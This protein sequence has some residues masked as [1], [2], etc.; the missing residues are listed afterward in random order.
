MKKI[1]DGI[2]I[3]NQKSVF[4]L[5]SFIKFALFGYIM[6]WE[7]WYSWKYRK[8]ITVILFILAYIVT[9]PIRGYEFF[10]GFIDTAQGVPIWAHLIVIIIGSIV[11]IEI[12]YILEIFIKK[13]ALTQTTKDTELNKK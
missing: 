10:D 4:N 7:K 11:V 3:F 13:Y 6:N 1:R 12:Q 8:F 2:V 9:I 5:D